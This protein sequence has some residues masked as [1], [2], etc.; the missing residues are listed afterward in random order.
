MDLRVEPWSD[1]RGGV[2]GGAGGLRPMKDSTIRTVSARLEEKGYL[3]H[4]VEG[5]TFIYR[6]SDERQNVAVRAVKGDYRSL[7][8]GIGR[9]VI[10]RHGGQRSAEPETTGTARAQDRREE[11]N[12]AMTHTNHLRGEVPASFL[13]SLA[14]AACARWY[15]A[16]VAGLGLSLFRAKATLVRLFTGRPCSIRTRN[17]SARTSASEDGVPTPAMWQHSMRPTASSNPGLAVQPISVSA[18]DGIS[19]SFGRET[20]VGNEQCCCRGREQSAIRWS[21]VALLVYV[22]VASF[23]ARPVLGGSCVHSTAATLITSD[24]R[25]AHRRHAWGAGEVSWTLICS[26]GDGI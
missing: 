13:W 23:L 15:L 10:A 8:R 7:L 22:S 16:G 19:T 5:R 3:S 2:P 1:V 12:R 20:D 17:A 18:A 11:G 4:E 14:T 26:A 21:Q 25:R 9:S 24:S 6:A